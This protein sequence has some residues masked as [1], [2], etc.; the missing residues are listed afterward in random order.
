MTECVLTNLRQAAQLAAMR[1]ELLAVD[2]VQLLS[3][4]TT[5][6]A[7]QRPAYLLERT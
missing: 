5:L 7:N 3:L 1:G 6:A 2:P 4:L